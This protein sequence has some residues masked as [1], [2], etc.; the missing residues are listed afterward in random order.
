MNRTKVIYKIPCKDCEKHYIGQTGRKLATRI[1]EHQLATKRHNQYSL[2][3]NHMDKENH[4]F[5]WDNIMI[6][7]QDKQK[8]AWEFVEAWFTTKKAINKHIEFNPIYAPLRRKTGN[9]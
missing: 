8:Q 7:G 4:Q 9:E 5:D 6:L 1:H 3:S 2:I